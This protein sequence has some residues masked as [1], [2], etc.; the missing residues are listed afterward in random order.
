M[1]SYSKSTGTIED[2]SGEWNVRP[3]AEPAIHGSM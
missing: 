3:G 1:H 2:V